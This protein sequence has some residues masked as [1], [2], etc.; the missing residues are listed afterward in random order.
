MVL[1]HQYSTQIQFSYKIP[2]FKKM[3]I[4]ILAV[5]GKENEKSES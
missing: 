2:K 5:S 3:Y 4:I 1:F